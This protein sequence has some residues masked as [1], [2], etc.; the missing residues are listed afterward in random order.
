MVS[1][2]TINHSECTFQASSLRC[3]RWTLW[4]LVR[5][6]LLTDSRC[7]GRIFW[8]RGALNDTLS[9]GRIRSARNVAVFIS[10]LKCST[11][12]LLAE[13]VLEVRLHQGHRWL[14]II[15]RAAVKGILHAVA[16]AATSERGS[17]IKFPR[18]G[19][20]GEVGPRVRLVLRLL[21]WRE[22][23]SAQRQLFD[24]FFAFFECSRL[25]EGWIL[26]LITSINRGGDDEFFRSPAWFWYALLALH[27]IL[28][29]CFY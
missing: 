20:F 10:L 9:S 11:P 2:Q 17:S 1:N 18:Q 14:G 4:L 24:L 13:F 15:W 8:L 28:R 25:F 23:E 6:F 16:E 26:P 3:L 5:K 27:L 19:I 21:L 22:S 12:C 7:L 29:F